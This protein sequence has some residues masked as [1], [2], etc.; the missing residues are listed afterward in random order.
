VDADKYDRGE[1]Q[2][3]LGVLA[4]RVIVPRV[5]V[6]LAGVHGH[7][8]HLGAVLLLRLQMHPL[9]KYPVPP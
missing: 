5:F 7:Q 1:L 2:D 8:H 9:Q 6:S 4:L 3:I